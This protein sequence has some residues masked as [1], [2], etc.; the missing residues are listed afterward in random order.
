MGKRKTN[1]NKDIV[2]QGLVNVNGII[3]IKPF[4]HYDTK[5]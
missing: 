3:I 2:Q 4:S 1:R 5:R